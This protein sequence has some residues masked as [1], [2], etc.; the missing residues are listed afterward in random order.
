MTL[1]S[2]IRS[3]VRHRANFCCE[4]CSVSEVDVGGELTI[5]HYRPTSCDGSDDL[6]NLLYCCARCN[7][8]K[9]N[10]WPTAAHA[11]ALWNPRDA[12]AELHLIELIDGTLHAIS[13][14]GQFTIARLRL[15]RP[16]LVQHR[17]RKRHVEEE[18]R[19]IQRIRETLRLLADLQQQQETL[20]R[21][22]QQL[23]ELQRKLLKLLTDIN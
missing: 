16:A 13:A 7:L 22:Q 1:G 14:I 18:Q 4:Y 12:P 6:E 23:L 15:N 9:A 10:Y 20:L 21:E 19:L 3:V 2:T 17:R 11:P 8:Y 5:D